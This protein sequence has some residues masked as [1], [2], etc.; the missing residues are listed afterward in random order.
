MIKIMPIVGVRPQIIKAAPL[1]KLIEKD[2]EFELM[3]VHSGQHYDYEMSK[4]FF[5]ELDL[6]NP[7]VNLNVGSGSHSYQTATLMLRL[8]KVITELDPDLV[9]V[10]GDANTTLGAA[11]ASIKSGIPVVHVESGLR[12]WDYRMP[13]EINRVLTD[14]ISQI[15]Y[16]PTEIAVQ[17][18]IREGISDD[19]IILSGDTMYDSIIYHRNSIR[20]SKILE[21]LNIDEDNYIVTTVHRAENV[22]DP[23]RLSSIVSALLE[24]S[25]LIKLVFPIHPRT[26]K[27]LMESSLYNKIIQDSNIILVDPVGYFDMLKLIMCSSC[28]ITD[29]GGVQK[30]AFILGTPCITLR[31]RTEWIETVRLGGNRLAGA[32]K[33]LIL[34]NVKDILK[35]FKDLK[36][37]LKRIKSPYGDGHAA[38]MIVNTL[39]ERFFNGGIVVSP[40][41]APIPDFLA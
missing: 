27:R 28:V 2:T 31:E 4:I 17:N 29:S 33:N 25:R 22:D 9:I 34:V 19:I 37:Y 10:F 39:K 26:K 41:P 8:E 12:S 24:I 6:P 40:R 21:Y 7:I 3:L 13:E 23:N 20:D 38:N 15:L 35:N 5:N 14:H 36:A 18:L 32:D 30:E 16:A 1:I 11:L